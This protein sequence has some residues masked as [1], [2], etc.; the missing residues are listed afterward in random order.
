MFLRELEGPVIAQGRA[1]FQLRGGGSMS[2]GEANAEL[3]RI[4]YAADP[5]LD[6]STGQLL[7][8]KRASEITSRIVTSGPDEAG[9]HHIA[10][11]ECSIELAATVSSVARRHG[12]RVVRSD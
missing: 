10:G 9:L 4:V 6:E 5:A 3:L 7:P 8:G 2:E 12:Y 11:L 1:R